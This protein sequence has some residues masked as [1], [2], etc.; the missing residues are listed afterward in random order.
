MEFST[1]RLY[2]P[3]YLVVLAYAL[4]GVEPPAWEDG[5]RIAVLPEDGD[6]SNAEY[7]T[8]SAGAFWVKNV[9]RIVIE[10]A[11]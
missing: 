1:D 9:A 6:V 2:D 11:D 7:R 5:L 4:G 8:D 3:D 10:T